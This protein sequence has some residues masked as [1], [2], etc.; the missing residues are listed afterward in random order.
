MQ[1]SSIIGNYIHYLRLNCYN[2]AKVDNRSLRHIDCFF[3]SRKYCLFG[4]YFFGCGKLDDLP[5][6]LCIFGWNMVA[7]FFLFE[8]GSLSCLDPHIHKK[9]EYFLYFLQR[10][11]FR[12]IEETTEIGQGTFLRFLN[13]FFVDILFVLISY[14]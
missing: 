8:Y 10:N 2:E 4:C 6:S 5:D 14:F 12:I 3:L 11:L 1:N 9:A 13:H 7:C